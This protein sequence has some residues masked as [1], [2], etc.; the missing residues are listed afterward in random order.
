VTK[1]AVSPETA[2]TAER[3]EAGEPAEATSWDAVVAAGSAARRV[4]VAV[5]GGGGGAEY[6]EPTAVVPK[7]YGIWGASGDGGALRRATSDAGRS[8]ELVVPEA[9]AVMVGE[10]AERR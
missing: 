2:G 9:E 10:A 6:M 7:N 8:P 4:A 5:L 1:A 3:V